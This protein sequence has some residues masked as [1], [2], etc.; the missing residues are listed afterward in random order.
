MSINKNNN[1]TNFLNLSPLV[2]VIDTGFSINNLDVNYSQVHLG[3]DFIDGN[4]H[5]LLVKGIGNNHGSYILKIIDAPNVPFLWLGRAVGSGKW[6]KSLVEFIEMA[7]ASEHRNAV[8]NLSFDLV[9]LN[10]DGS[11]T[12]RYELTAQERSAIEYA[13][14]NGILIVAASGNKN[15]AVSALGQ[16]S[17]DYDNIITVGATDGFSR[18]PYSS[19]G[20]G[21]TLVANGSIFGVPLGT[22]AATAQVTKAI[23]QIWAVSPEL[24]YQQIID[25][26]KTTAT[27]LNA[28]GWDTE[29]G[30][31]LLNLS[32]A[33]NLA[34]TTIPNR[35]HTFSENTI[36][37]WKASA[38]DNIMAVLERP[39]GFFE[40]VGDFFEDVGNGIG[41][42][43]TTI[44]GVLIDTA[45]FPFKTVGEA[46]E[47][48]T[49]KAGDGLKAGF[50]LVGLNVVGNAANFIADKFGEKTQAIL[51]RGAQYI[52]K[53]PDRIGRTANDLFS[54]NLWNNFGRWTA[55]NLTNIAE[56]SGIPEISETYADLIKFNTRELNDREQDIARSVFGDSINLNL[57]RIDEYSVF[58]TKAINDGR[59]F[60]TFNTINTWDPLDDATLIHELSHVWQY[61]KV[62]AIY[63]PDALTSQN[64]AGVPGEEDTYPPGVEISGSTGYRYG[65]FI[66]LEKRINNG[67]KLSSFNYEQQASIIEDYYKI[68]SDN[69]TD[70]NP[71]LPLYAYFVKEVS[72][73]PLTTLIPDSFGLT[74]TIGTNN[75]DR[76]DGDNRDNTIFGLAGDDFIDGGL[77]DDRM[78]GGLGNDTF[79]VNSFNDLVKEFSDQGVDTV[80]SFIRYTLGDNLENLTLIGNSALVGTGNSLDNI[81]TGNGTS[82][83]LAGLAGNDTLKGLAGAD[84]LIGGVG[85]DTLIGGAGD[86]TAAYT[87]SPQGV[88][89]NLVTGQGFGG[90]ATGDTLQSIENIEG[91]EF[92]DTFI[93]NVDSNELDGR[94]GTD[95]VSYVNSTAGVNVNLFTEQGFGGFASGDILINIENIQ[96]SDFDDTL[97]GDGKINVLNGRGGND[98]LEG[99]A[100]KDT[101]IGGAGFDTVSYASSSTGVVIDLSTGSASG[102]DAD[103]DI[104]IEIE[105]LSGSEF[106]DTLIG[107]N[108]SNTFSGLGGDDVLQGRG[109]NDRLNGGAGN[110]SI[111]GGTNID[112]V[113]YDTSFNGVVVNIDETQAYSNT[114]YP[115]DIE[116]TFSIAS[117]TALD[118]FGSTDT[119][120]NLENII[121]SAYDDILI[122]NALKN[123]LNGLNGNDLLIG[124]GGDD[125]LDG[126]NGTDTVSYRRSVNSSNIGVSVDLSTGIGFDGIDGLDT[127]ISIENLIGS[128]F[129]DRLIGNSQANTILGGD[130][131]D[132]IDGKEG[133]DR[134]FGEA[135]TDSLFGQNGNDFLVG[136]TDADLLDGGEGNDTASY[137]TSAAPVSVSLTTGTGWAGDAQGDRLQAIE[138]LEGSEFED[139]LIGDS[140][141]NILS[142]LGGS[143]LL[144]GKA[145]ADL[146][147]GGLGS[148]RLYGGDG[149][150][151]LYGRDGEDLLKGEAGDDLLF[152]NDGNDRLYGQDGNDTLNGDA[153]ND[154]LDGGLGN[155]LLSGGYGDDRLY[156]QDGEDL[157]NGEMG[158][159]LLDGGLGNDLLNGGDGDDQ[160][161]GRAG[162]DTLNGGTG[163][164]LL[165]GGEGDDLL[166]GNEGNDRLYGQAGADLLN[167]NE[168][169]DLL[170]GGD[171]NDILNG[172]DGNDQLY[173]QA[174]DDLLNGQA[175]DDALYGGTGKDTLSGQVGNDYL[176]GG[177]G[178]DLLN[179][180]EGN[181][182]LYGQAG[183]DL[184]N[185]NTGDDYLDGGLDND[186]LNGNEG[187]DRLYGQQNYDILD[188][189]AGAD[190]LD[191]G[192]ADDFL[193]GRDGS[194]RLYGQTGNDYL[195]GNAGDDRLEGGDGDDQLFGQQGRDY[196]DGGNGDDFLLGGEAADKLLGQ[197]GNDYLDGGDGNDDLLGGDGNDQLYG[198][199]DNDTLEGGAGNDYLD[200]GTGDDRLLAGQG[201]DFLYGR[202]GSDILNGESGNDNLDGGLGDD[203]LFGGDGKDLL[204]GR[205]GN[206]LLDAGAGD[207]YIDGGLGND[208]ILAGAGN[209]QIYAG[210]GNDLIDAGAGNDYVE[211]GL[212]DDQLFGGE[213]N[214][215]L[216]AQDGN[217]SV[218]GGTGNDLLV[219]GIDADL[220]KG[221]LGDD[222]LYGEAGNDQLYG[223]AGN[224]SLFGGAGNDLLYAGDGD[225]V[226]EGG[227]GQDTLYGGSGRN[228]FVVGMGTGTDTI[229][230][231]VAG[232]DYFG[233]KDGLTFDTLTIAQGTGVNANNTLISARGELLASLVTVQSST[234]SLW[235]FAP[236]QK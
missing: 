42:G 149:D 186:Q 10:P 13:R 230:N 201:D 146:L 79:V 84:T 233:L 48:V 14:Q 135:G 150:D 170:D 236:M 192:E 173:G 115:S 154:D 121:G 94:S 61:G 164:D 139:L 105:G 73:L 114:D 133:N 53:L 128:Q 157:L 69:R 174:G 142:G 140:G 168:G 180:N 39:A 101:L 202:D 141:N 56:L 75:A 100:G 51:E 200:G 18:A 217:D 89:I 129:A 58:A 45:A 17:Q 47:F 216:Y 221:G 169:N 32:S 191:G 226:L 104:L 193:Y 220:L 4:D 158:D 235:D 12:T 83:T 67:Q 137:F 163:N 206:D 181:D 64:D 111:D 41:D 179:G 198:R 110:D 229:F 189:G 218:N 57:V 85:A 171:S 1:T 50:D 215:Q 25:I 211:S 3:S 190:F 106:S 147:D 212:G 194:D 28:T 120:R 40:D 92:D 16:A 143:D 122:G 119:L 98:L 78:Y 112:T 66:E 223:D 219:G 31:G 62:G 124:N 36:P 33:L 234:L 43:V 144:Y 26:L 87:T 80:N 24:S 118:G 145:G 208:Q 178:N 82:N 213:G 231:F 71:S 81:I 182:R 77:G 127:L 103:G 70:N 108:N 117:G 165:D 130:G 6:A 209:D 86:D 131:N 37:V 207:D 196:L 227:F 34:I 102:G 60:T 38:K 123:T 125:I 107:D 44:G 160:L 11:V 90:D 224:D 199:A 232:K 172:G 2:G 63:I 187:N 99:G 177:D 76:I 27:E 161:Y 88:T 19:Y 59:P 9:Q 195:E 30:F 7:K 23:A 20:N 35:Q 55:E 93:A 184:L 155:D 228:Q 138:N 152:G 97:T 21:L 153:G 183:D 113:I 188:G 46:I 225:N 185:G 175:G 151:L 210:N 8:V 29:T 204:Y 126:G 52:E 96:G 72:S 5:P 109:G 162:T 91:S 68:R 176:E 65:G 15:D 203:Q 132:I 22:S 148:D 214:D 95:T 49:D 222:Y 167:G 205:D 116:P 159:D 156:G 166:N 136:G 54:E 74:L 134:L 197:A